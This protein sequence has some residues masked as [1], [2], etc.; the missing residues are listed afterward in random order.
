MLDIQYFIKS[1]YGNDLMYPKSDDA[2]RIARIYGRETINEQ[3]IE[4]FIDWI[5]GTATEVLPDRS[6]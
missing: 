5:G 6:K 1:V 4:Y 2:K 3:M